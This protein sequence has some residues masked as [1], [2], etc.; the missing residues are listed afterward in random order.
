MTSHLE[1]T[2]EAFDK[3]KCPQCG[4]WFS[5]CVDLQTFIIQSHIAYLDREIEKL[6]EAKRDL[7]DLPLFDKNNYKCGH[8]SAIQNQINHLQFQ[9]EEANNSIK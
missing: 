2:K 5:K 7:G 1:K 6:E 3:L 9:L 8:A 4:L